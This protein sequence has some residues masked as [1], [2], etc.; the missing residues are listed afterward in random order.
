MILAYL[1]ASALVKLVLPE[2]ESDAIHKEIRQWPAR[3]T[4]V[5]GAIELRRTVRKAGFDDGYVR[6]ADDALRMTASIAIT[7]E[8]I[9]GAV[10]DVPT[11]LRSLDAI[12]LASALSLGSDLGAFIAYDGRLLDAA[13]ELGLPVLSPA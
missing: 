13:R 11:T 9:D 5:I 8:I 4:S 1:D 10:R 3:A 6:R 12:H 2:A 7:G